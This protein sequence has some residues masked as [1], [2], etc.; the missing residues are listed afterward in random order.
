M[1]S[2]DIQQ[3]VKLVSRDAV[4]TRD[5]WNRFEPELRYCIFSSH[6]H[7]QGLARNSFV[8]VEEEPVALEMAGTPGF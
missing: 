8:G 3:L 6:V 2:R 4:R 1:F 7:V 5:L